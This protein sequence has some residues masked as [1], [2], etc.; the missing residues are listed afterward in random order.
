MS[1]GKVTVLNLYFYGGVEGCLNH[2][3]KCLGS[4]RVWLQVT[5]LVRLCFLTRLLTPPES[6]PFCLAVLVRTKHHGEVPGES[7][8]YLF[9]IQV[10]FKLRSM[11]G[12]AGPWDQDYVNQSELKTTENHSK[13]S[14]CS[15]QVETFRYY[16][17]V[18]HCGIPILIPDPKG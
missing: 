4:D 1:S 12:Q 6:W 16:R 7:V 10:I 13:E 17:N 14:C 11:A 18:G 9:H 15:A 3:H 2:I 5:G 8:T